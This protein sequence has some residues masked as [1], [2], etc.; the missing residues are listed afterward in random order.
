MKTSELKDFL[1]GLFDSEKLKNFPNEYG[2]SINNEEI[3]KIGFCTN[4]T[5][6]VVKKAV[7]NKVDFLLT[8]HDAWNFIYGMKEKCLVELE[9]NRISHGFFHL[10]LDDCDFGTNVSFLRRLNVEIIEK[11]SLE[12]EAFYC[13][14]IGEFREPIEF[15][16][17]VNRVETLLEEPV[18]SWKNNENTIRRIGFLSGTGF[19]TSEMKEYFDKKCD[20]YITGEKTL[21][22]VEYA[23]FVKMNLII[24]SHTFTEIFGMESIAAKVRELGQSIEIIKISERHIE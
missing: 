4:L 9:K 2:F 19:F 11:T 5:P 12:E 22:T 21:Y 20:V 1:L 3:N 13:G 8:H 18:K 23:E 6:E 17:L 24:G 15:D 10:L 7:E 14:R 16:V